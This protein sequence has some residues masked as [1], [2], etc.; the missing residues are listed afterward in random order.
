MR[1]SLISVVGL[2][3]TIIVKYNIKKVKVCCLDLDCTKPKKNKRV[4]N[5]KILEE[6]DDEKYIEKDRIT[7]T[8]TLESELKP[9]P[10]LKPI[11]ILI[12][13]KKTL[14]R[15]EDTIINDIENPVNKDEYEDE[16]EYEYE[17][18]DEDEDEDEEEKDDEDDYEE[19]KDD[20]D[21]TDVKKLENTI[22]KITNLLTEETQV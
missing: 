8:N 14:R 21:I 3:S 7:I 11:P 15:K 22:I 5:S 17:Y 10:K 16:D 9:K 4:K 19:E 6:I 13:K 2:F 20:E 12:A 18:E 1:I